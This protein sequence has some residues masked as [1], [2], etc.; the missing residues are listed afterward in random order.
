MDIGPVALTLARTTSE[1]DAE[2]VRRLSFPDMALKDTREMLTMRAKYFKDIKEDG[3]EV[4]PK[5]RSKLNKGTTTLFL[6]IIA[7]RGTH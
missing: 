6:T 2:L 3:V 1:I 5:C 4:A 7:S